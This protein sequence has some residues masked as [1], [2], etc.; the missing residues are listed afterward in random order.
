MNKYLKYANKYAIL[1]NP[2]Q[3]LLYILAYPIAVIAKKIGL[4]PNGLTLI[5]LIFTG[6]AF[7]ALFKKNL[8]S[9]VLYWFIAFILDYA[10]G[11]LARLINLKRKT[12]LRIDHFSD[13]L[14]ILIIL[15]GFGMYYNNQII[16]V[17]VFLSSSLYLFYTVLNHELNW[18]NNFETLT[19]DY[20]K[21][22]KK[23]R[24]KYKNKLNLFF[25]DL[26]KSNVFKGLIM[27][28]ISIFFRINGHTLLIF[29][30][31][32]QN[33]NLAFISLIYFITLIILRSFQLCIQLNNKKI[34]KKT[35]KINRYF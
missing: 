4:K 28:M 13:L 26:K 30:L 20:L 16:W 18:I 6:L 2:V 35:K 22:N 3:K 21:K 29:F 19:S 10:D 33:T 15:L 24:N 5:S 17:L 12:A 23:I 8:D 31:I 27:A 11:S 7:T 9:F 1:N 32:P 34:E 25:R 14:K